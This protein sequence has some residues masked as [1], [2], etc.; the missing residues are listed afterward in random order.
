[1]SETFFKEKSP[2]ELLE[3]VRNLDTGS[4]GAHSQIYYMRTHNLDENSK[5]KLEIACKFP[6]EYRGFE[7]LDA[8]LEEVEDVDLMRRLFNANKEEYGYFIAV[9]VKD[10]KFI[11]ELYYS[12]V[13][14]LPL[15]VADNESTNIDFLRKIISETDD[16]KVR[17]TAMQTLKRIS[18]T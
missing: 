5:V 9:S 15:A 1:M 4:K 18:L 10:E 11:E 13:E 6:N 8:I 17:E 3:E 2:Q 7:I 16:E 12:K 14:D